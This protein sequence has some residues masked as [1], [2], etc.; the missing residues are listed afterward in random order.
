MKITIEGEEKEIATLLLELEV[1]RKVPFVG[2][3]RY[4][5]LDKQNA[6]TTDESVKEAP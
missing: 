3:V 4:C 5:S 1:Q 6:H 2:E